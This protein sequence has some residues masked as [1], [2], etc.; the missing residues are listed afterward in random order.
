PPPPPPAPPPPMTAAAAAARADGVRAMVGFSY[1]RVPAIAFAKRL[2]EDGR[3]GTVRQVRALYLQDW[4]ADEDGPMTWRLD[5]ALAGSGS[6]G[7]IGAHAIDLVEHVTGAQLS[8]VSGTLETFVTERPLMAEGV[9]LSGTAST[10]RGQ[11]TVDDAAFFL[12]RLAGGAADGAI[13]S[14]EATRYATGRKNGLTLEIS[15]SAGA[16]QFDLESMNELRFYDATAP[17]GEQGFQPI[18]VTEPEHPYMAAWWPT[19]HLIGYEHTFSHEVKDFVEAIVAGTDP[20][21][22]F[23]DGLHV[24]RVLDAVERSAAD[25]SAWTVI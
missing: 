22:S 11:V 4:L 13:G 14:F 16:I 15:G 23:E 2:V 19:G 8:T 12:G 25:G 17:A 18:L 5:K 10:E 7:D 24:Q 21:P 20:S 3:L 1:R 6:L 9:G